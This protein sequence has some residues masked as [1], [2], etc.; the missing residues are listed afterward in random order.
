M[1]AAGFYPKPFKGLTKAEQSAFL[2][3]H[4]MR[5]TAVTMLARAGNSLPLICFV[6]GHTLQSAT[7]IL[8]KYLARTSAMSKTAILAF[9]NNPATD[10]FC[11][12]AL[13]Q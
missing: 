8:K 13:T 5:G 4:E 3:L 2:H 11:K 1:E 6:P 10:F 9:E 12:P 7:R